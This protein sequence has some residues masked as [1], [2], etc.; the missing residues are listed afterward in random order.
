MKP[1]HLLVLL[2]FPLARFGRGESP[3]GGK[4]DG[5]NGGV[6]FPRD[7]DKDMNELDLSGLEEDI[8]GIEEIAHTD[9]YQYVTQLYV[10]VRIDK[11]YSTFRNHL[12]LIRLGEKFMTLLQN[13]MINVQMKKTGVGIFTCFYQDKAITENLVTYFLMQKEVDFLEVGFDRRFPEGRSAPF[14]DVD[15]RIDPQE[16][17]DEEL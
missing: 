13:A 8:E 1:F 2:I 17:T 11:K 10:Y 14:V 3:D 16:K 5:S 12:Q 6:V 4:G 7:F 9:Y 15:E